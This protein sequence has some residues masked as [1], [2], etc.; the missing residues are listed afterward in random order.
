MAPELSYSLKQRNLDILDTSVM[1][2]IQLGR[3]NFNFLAGESVATDH[4]E[5]PMES[6]DSAPVVI[7]SAL[8]HVEDVL[9]MLTDLHYLQSCN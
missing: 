7:A 5:S 9:G 4:L 3:Q 2:S 8:E 6:T 1:V